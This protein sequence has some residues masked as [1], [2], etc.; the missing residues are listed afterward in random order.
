MKKEEK[1]QEARSTLETDPSPEK[2][3]ETIGRKK[4]FNGKGKPYTL[5]TTCQESWKDGALLQALKKQY[6]LC[7]VYFAVPIGWLLA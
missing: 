7:F 6:L 4:H 2:S 5:Y 3:R 1:I